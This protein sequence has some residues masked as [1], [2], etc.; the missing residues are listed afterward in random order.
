MVRLKVNAVNK[1]V[2]LKYASV[3]RSVRL[4]P[5]NSR[6]YY[7]AYARHQFD[8]RREAPASEIP[9]LLEEADRKVFWVMKKYLPQNQI[10][11]R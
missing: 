7:R 6:N 10:P 8:S 1:F 11:M 5:E 3:L 4:L 9:K 2:L